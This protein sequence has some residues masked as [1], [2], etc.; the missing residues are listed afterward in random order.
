METASYQRVPIYTNRIDNTVGTVATGFSDVNS[1]YHSLVATVRKPMSHGVEFLA[2]YTWAKA[3]DG[4]QTYGGNGTFNGTDAPLIPNAEGRGV[5]RSG[6][7]A[8]SDL[9]IR[10]RLVMTLV[11]VSK[12]SIPNRFAAYAANGWKLSTSYTAQTGEP[13]TATVSGTISYLTG[14]ALGTPGRALTTDAGV[15]NAAFTSG[16][17]A[18]VPDFIARRN[19][20]NGPGVHNADA[21]IAREFPLY[22][23]VH[24]ELA[25]EL[26]NVANH[27]N[28][29][30][31]STPIV[32]YTAPTA[33]ST[34]CPS[35]P[36]AT[37]TNCVGSL[38]PLPSTSAP[39]GSPTS[40][41]NIIYGA[42]QL[43]LL[44][45]IVF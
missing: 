5:G 41:S 37:A 3:M 19:G 29:L 39:F 22:E 17:G 1:N 12:F 9:D 7:Y 25:A 16:P 32:A 40:T 35:V 23:G 4:G 45:R 38:A 33:N 15:T 28:I 26:F 44:G 13:V 11:A 42:R 31:V 6:E 18:R 43:Q 30:S 8:R 34:T 36:T 21:R 27:R 10:G 24:I 2:N 14:G 20:F